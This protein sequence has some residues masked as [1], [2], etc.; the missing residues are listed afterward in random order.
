MTY[1]DFVDELAAAG[2][3]GRE[4]A[5]LLRLNTNTIANYKSKGE[6]PSNLAVIATLM[7]LLT[8][9][10]VS[11]KERL[12]ALDIQPNASRGKSIATKSQ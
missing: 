4:L 5:R 2:I 11:Y 7:R 10:N 1:E 3:S 12:E 8:E 6:V 9:N